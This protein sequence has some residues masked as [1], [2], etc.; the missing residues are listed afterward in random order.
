MT[1][2]YDQT[3]EIY[4]G[5][6]VCALCDSGFKAT[7]APRAVKVLTIDGHIPESTYIEFS[8]QALD[9]ILKAVQR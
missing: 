6:R 4:S 7:S 2:Y 9:K 3:T 5:R 8:Q 1:S